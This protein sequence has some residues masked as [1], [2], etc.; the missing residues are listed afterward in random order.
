ML[1]KR[2][3][4]ECIECCPVI[5]KVDI[6]HPQLNYKTK[7]KSTFSCWGVILF[8]AFIG[9]SIYFI[10]HEIVC[11]KQNYSFSYS[12]EF[13]L[14]KDWK[15]KEITIGFNVSEEWKNDVNIEL[16]DSQDK[17]VNYTQCD[18]NLEESK[19][20]T[21][22]CIINHSITTNN[23]NDYI[24]KFKLSLKKSVETKKI[25]HFS[26]AMKEPLIDHDDLKNPILLEYDSSVKKF[27]CF[28]STD[29]ITDYGKYLKLIDYTTKGGFIDDTQI[30]AIYLDDYLDS[31]KTRSDEKIGELLGFYRIM[32]SKKI[33]VYQRE[34]ISK[35]NFIKNIF[36]S[37]GS[38]F[39][40]CSIVGFLIIS[41]NDTNRLYSSLEN[42]K[43]STIYDDYK[44]RTQKEDKEI[45]I[46]KNE[47]EDNLQDSG[48]FK[49]LCQRFCFI[50]CCCCDICPLTRH[51]YI[52]KDYFDEKLSIENQ[53][54]EERNNNEL[55]NY[56]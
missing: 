23:Q 14:R 35:T 38:L 40:I 9:I 6:F 2:P 1:C 50:F 47:F 44:Q 48:F 17:A 46:N 21:F 36:S 37:I 53:I 10:V 41:P 52:V 39:T 31:R 26:V 19:N 27:R 56:I 15:G 30:N 45:K 54:K 24:L 16:Y 28:Y 5:T 29:E 49:S 55:L 42:I 4:D 20:G 22:F 32:V 33:D 3:K 34:Y 13:I 12:Q 11:I 51:L 7:R 43:S 8:F 25:I 18:D